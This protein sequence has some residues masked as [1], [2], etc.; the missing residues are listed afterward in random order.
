VTRDAHT[1]VDTPMTRANI[2]G[3][4]L[5]GRRTGI[6]LFWCMAV[7]VIGASAGSVISELYGSADPPAND[8]ETVAC[9][10]ELTTLQRQLLDKASAELRLPRDPTRSKR[11]L[12]DWDRRY[13]QTR[14]QCGALHDTRH[15]LL[16]LRERIE[17]LLHAYARDERPLTER[18]ERALQR[19]APRS[20]PPRET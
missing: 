20:T 5:I 12:S 10:A 3:A 18:I 4:A 15:T 13:V 2:Q 9:A 16:T 8:A 17:A 11:W 6:T 14:E 1:H 7:F 19:F